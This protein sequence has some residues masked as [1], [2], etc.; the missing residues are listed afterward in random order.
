MDALRQLT[1]IPLAA[2]ATLC[3]V[4]LMKTLIETR[5]L[6]DD[7]LPPPARIVFISNDL[8]EL[9]NVEPPLP[10]E[11]PKP[12]APEPELTQEQELPVPVQQEQKQVETPPE[13]KAK[14]S[15]KPVQKS[16]PKPKKKV[17]KQTT[18]SRV[19][20]AKFDNTPLYR[21]K[22]HYPH[23]ARR[24]GVE[25]YVTVRYT[26][27]KSGGVTN[28]GIVSASP[29][30]I[31]NSAALSAVKRWRFRPQPIDRPGQKSRIR[32]VLR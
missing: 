22:P 2:M 1:A 28:V 27:T 20:R 13:P 11:P 5:S 30:G 18:K 17:V 21:P 19:S 25:G 26:V 6:E 31:F 24:R 15:V 10:N 29:S 14:L 8:E 4:W 23:N 12:Q 9:D 3:L 16:R 32:F 7:F